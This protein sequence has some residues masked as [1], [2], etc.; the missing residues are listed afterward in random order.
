MF[1]LRLDPQ[2]R[3]LEYASAGH[4]AGFVLDA[5]G[6]VK[7]TLK[8]TGIPL[9]MKL[10]TEYKPAPLLTLAPGDLVLLLT[11]GIEEAS[12]PD[13][14]LFGLERILEVVRAHREKPSRAIVEALYEATRRFA[15][16]TPQLDDITAIVIKAGG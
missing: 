15:G 12:A 2:K 6:A 11:D 4:P 10:D 13:E 9:G 1:L 7:A 5:T 3:E 14:S 16:H 8:R